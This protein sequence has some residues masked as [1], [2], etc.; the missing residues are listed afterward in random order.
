V[1]TEIGKVNTERE[2]E[3]EWEKKLVEWRTTETIVSLFRDR[4]SF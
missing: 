2:T 3:T 4:A 1:Q